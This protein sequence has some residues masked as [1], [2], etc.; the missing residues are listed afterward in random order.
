M[1]VENVSFELYTFPDDKLYP[2]LYVGMRAHVAVVAIYPEGVYQ[3]I[4]IKLKDTNPGQFFDV[5]HVSCKHGSSVNSSREYK[6]KEK[7]G[8]GVSIIILSILVFKTLYHIFNHTIFKKFRCSL[9]IR[10]FVICQTIG[11]MKSLKENEINISA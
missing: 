1:F 7:I 6:I 9:C 2:E 10:V 8:L 4:T 5:T 3:N 11:G